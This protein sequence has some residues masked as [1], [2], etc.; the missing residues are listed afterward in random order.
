MKSKVQIDFHLQHTI[1][2]ENSRDPDDVTVDLHW[3]FEFNLESVNYLKFK[4]ESVINLM[5]LWIQPGKCELFEIQ[6]G[7]SH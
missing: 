3:K 2:H 1:S 7:I 4:E 5:K 6:R